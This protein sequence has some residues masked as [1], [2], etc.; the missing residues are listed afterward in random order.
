VD[1]FDFDLG[2][3]SETLFTLNFCAIIHFEGTFLLLDSLL[4]AVGT[5]VD[6]EDFTEGALQITNQTLTSFDFTITYNGESDFDEGDTVSGS[7]ALSGPPTP[8]STVTITLSFSAS[9][10]GG[11]ILV[12]TLPSQPVRV[13]AQL[14]NTQPS[15]PIEAESLL[16]SGRVE[17]VFEGEFFGTVQDNGASTCRAVTIVDQN[18][19]ID[20]EQF[21]DGPGADATFTIE[22]FYDG[23]MARF[24][25]TIS[26]DNVSSRS[27]FDGIPVPSDELFFFFFVD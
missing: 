12:R 18:T 13:V 19:P 27:Y 10:E 6:G 16:F 24:A 1:D 8:G 25:V 11:E 2:L 21:L 22:S 15:E 5:F 9:L 17:C 4:D 20:L 26:D 3:D 14:A 7:V 23:H